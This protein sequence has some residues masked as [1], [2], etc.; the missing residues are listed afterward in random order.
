MILLVVTLVV[1]TIS[2]F[3]SLRGTARADTLWLSDSDVASIEA[4]LK[5]HPALTDDQLREISTMKLRNVLGFPRQPTSAQANGVTRRT[6]FLVVPLFVVVVGIIVLLKTCYPSA[7]FLWGD[8]VDRYASV[9]Q[10]R[11]IIWNIIIGV[12]VVGVLA[13][14]LFQGMLLWL[15][16]GQS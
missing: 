4:M 7:V 11:K 8:E 12:V 5:E 2:P 16:R 1:A 9:V 14:F 13:N 3:I 6:P 10:R 15:P